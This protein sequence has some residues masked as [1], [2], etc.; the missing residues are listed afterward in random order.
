MFFKTMLQTEK[1]IRIVDRIVG[2]VKEAARENI[3]GAGR[4]LKGCVDKEAAGSR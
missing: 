4:R 1:T 3:C 2:N